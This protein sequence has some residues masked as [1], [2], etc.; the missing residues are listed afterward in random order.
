MVKQGRHHFAA[1]IRGGLGILGDITDTNNADHAKT[2]L[3]AQLYVD[4]DD[5]GFMVH[6]TR[7][8]KLKKLP[9][10]VLKW[11]E[12]PLITVQH[13]PEFYADEVQDSMATPVVAIT[14]RKKEPTTNVEQ[15]H[16]IS[17]EVE[18][19]EVR[20]SQISIDVPDSSVGERPS[21]TSSRPNSIALLSD[22]A[23]TPLGIRAS[24]PK[25]A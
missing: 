10:Q 22:H 13:P 2:M 1:W 17:N 16:D 21:V 20:D 9:R 4:L 19:L 8:D 7:T 23:R 5:D 6:F 15:V 12:Q 24:L 18:E 25:K 14:D 3:W 11:Y